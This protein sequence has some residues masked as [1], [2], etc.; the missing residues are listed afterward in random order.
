MKSIIK[1]CVAS[2]LALHCAIGMEENA[3]NINGIVNCFT[4]KMV[5]HAIAQTPNENT[6]VC[7]LGPIVHLLA[8][9]ATLSNLQDSKSI[10]SRIQQEI[11]SGLGLTEQDNEDEL[12][13]N[14]FHLTEN[15]VVK[16]AH[17]ML[18]PYGT[19]DLEATSTLEMKNWPIQL[20]KID[21]S[22]PKKI[23]EDTNSYVTT[24]TSGC[25]QNVVTAA[26]FPATTSNALISSLFLQT[27]WI[28]SF[29]E[30]IVKFHGSNGPKLVEGLRDTQEGFVYD[31]PEGTTD[32]FKIIYLI[33]ENNI[34]FVMKIQDNRQISPITQEEFSQSAKRHS[35]NLKMPNFNFRQG[36]DLKFL[37]ETFPTLLTQEYQTTITTQPAGI[38]QFKQENFIEVDWMGLKAGSATMH[39]ETGLGSA[40]DQTRQIYIDGPFSFLVIQKVKTDQK[41]AQNFIHWFGGA[42]IDVPEAPEIIQAKDEY[43]WDESNKSIY[44]K[45]LNWDIQSLDEM[46]YRFNQEGASAEE[47]QKIEKLLAEKKAEYEIYKE[48]Y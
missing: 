45:T 19:S 29:Q 32:P 3:P 33:G 15:S 39:V 44:R 13:Q 25:V 35:I 46:K 7:A 27:K 26:D 47:L 41:K 4:Q 24:K 11:R 1:G 40:P 43:S 10:E 2:F 22:D 6:I 17:L 30:T 8:T 31:S 9:S 34:F 21:L 18:L 16:Q 5:E 12:L 23:S 28:S 36:L 42:V 37:S 48:Y 14:I 38:S 20:K